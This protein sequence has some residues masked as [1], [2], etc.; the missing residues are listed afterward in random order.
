VQPGFS[1]DVNPAASVKKIPAIRDGSAGLLAC[2]EKLR[3]EL[4]LNNDQLKKLTDRIPL[5]MRGAEIA[6]K[7]S[8]LSQVE[9]VLWIV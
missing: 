5:A 1:K 6:A 9:V 2:M 7:V 8:C 4:P 3:V